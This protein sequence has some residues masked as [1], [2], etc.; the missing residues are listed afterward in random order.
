MKACAASVAGSA[1]YLL[2]IHNET[3]QS[4][5]SVFV[6]AAGHHFSHFI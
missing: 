4:I 5:I 3:K 2:G 6:G 1:H